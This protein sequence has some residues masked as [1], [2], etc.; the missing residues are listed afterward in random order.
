MSDA[1]T[2]DEVLASADSYKKASSNI[3]PLAADVRKLVDRAELRGEIK[4][5]REASITFLHNLLATIEAMHN[6]SKP[7]TG[8]ILNDTVII[9][10]ASLKAEL[11]DTYG[12]H[13]AASMIRNIALALSPQKQ[14]RVLAALEVEAK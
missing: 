2:L 6:G 4:G 9:F 8:Q 7:D 1:M 3:A 11:G 10:L 14:A 13:C 5:V 12:S